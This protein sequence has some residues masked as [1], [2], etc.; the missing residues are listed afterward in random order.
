VYKVV[1]LDRKFFNKEELLFYL[2]EQL[3]KNETVTIS[4]L[5]EGP[6]AYTNHLFSILDKFCEHTGYKKQDISVITTNMLEHHA[7]YNIVKNTSGMFYLEPIKRW[8]LENNIDSSAKPTKHFGNFIGRSN[9][10]RLWLATII[11][12]KYNTA[13]IQTFNSAPKINYLTNDTD[14]ISDYFGLEDLIKFECDIIP[15]VAEF[16]D[17]CPILLND[18]HE[19]IKNCKS[20]IIKTDR[21]YP[22]Y[23]PANLNILNFY[24]HFFIDIVVETH[25]T[26]DCFFMSE[27]TFRPFIAKRPFIIMGPVNYLAN[28]K[29]LGFK[30][31]NEFWDEGYDEYGNQNRIHQIDGLLSVLSEKSVDQMQTMLDNMSDILE[32]NYKNFMKLTHQ[33]IKDAFNG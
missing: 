13:S 20:E 17:H 33:Q 8:V 27:K 21:Y 15:K 14:G 24:Q 10:N 28:L 5:P 12:M 22:L 16:L 19:F 25:V 29:R 11:N 2:Y 4:L 7:E 23:H 9:W 1:A 6:S 26:G 32:H 3:S 31:F 30:T 18:D